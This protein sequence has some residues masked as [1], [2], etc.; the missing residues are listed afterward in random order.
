MFQR[1]RDLMSSNIPIFKAGADLKEALK[2]TS[3]ALE[4]TGFVAVTNEAYAYTCSQPMVL[5]L[6]KFLYINLTPSWNADPKF[7]GMDCF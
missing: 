2:I 6:E 3:T 1:F 7:T 4:D 5:L